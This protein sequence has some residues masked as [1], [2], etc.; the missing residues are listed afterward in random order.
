MGRPCSTSVRGNAYAILP[1]T[2]E[3]KKQF[4]KTR[5]GW[6]NSIKRDLKVLC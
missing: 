2:P 1:G 4:D 5:R 6:K 3:G